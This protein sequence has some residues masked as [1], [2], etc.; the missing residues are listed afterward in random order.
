MDYRSECC[1]I[2]LR[3]FP[4]WSIYFNVSQLS[5]F[6]ESRDCYQLNGVSMNHL[7]TSISWLEF[8][9]WQCN[10]DT[11]VGWPKCKISRNQG[12]ISILRPSSK[13]SLICTWVAELCDWGYCRA[14]CESELTR[15]RKCLIAQAVETSWGYGQSAIFSRCR[16]LLFCWSCPDISTGLLQAWWRFPDA[17][18]TRTSLDS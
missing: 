10:L 14:S 6:P 1:N 16:L 7:T 3:S 4:S 11:T 9:L 17:V 5:I 18:R 15:K 2:W 13:V 8:Q 12:K